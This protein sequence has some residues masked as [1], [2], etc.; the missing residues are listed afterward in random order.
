VDL[1]RL[2]H[3]AL[4]VRDLEKS[5]AWYRDVLGLEPFTVESWGGEPVFVMAADRSFGIAL[6]RAEESDERPPAPL[7]VLHIAF[8]TDR[9]GFEAA[10]ETLRAKGVTFRS[11]DHDVS[12][13][14]YLRDPDG[15][16]LEITTYR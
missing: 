11:A 9:K 13:S 12:E 1:H 16:V 2:D 6:F 15:H 10:Q 5:V 7:R 3:V 4:T 14:I 8:G